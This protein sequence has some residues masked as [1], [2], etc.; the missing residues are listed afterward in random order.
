MGKQESNVRMK[1][2][3]DYDRFIRGTSSYTEKIKDS[4]AAQL[5]LYFVRCTRQSIMVQFL[6]HNGIRGDESWKLNKPV[7]IKKNIGVAEPLIEKTF[8]KKV[9]S[10]NEELSQKVQNGQEE[11]KAIST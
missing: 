9:E 5:G 3:F 8:V 1:F 7:T 11:K 6:H 10:M 2:D 4:G